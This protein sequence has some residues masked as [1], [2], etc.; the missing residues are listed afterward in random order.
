MLVIALLASPAWAQGCG[1]WIMRGGTEYHYDASYER[2]KAT[3]TGHAA[4]SAAANAAANNPAS[5]ANESVQMDRV[6]EKEAVEGSDGK[7][8]QTNAATNQT[9][10][11][12]NQ[13][14]QTV[15]QTAAAPKEDVPVEDPVVDLAGDWRVMIDTT[16]EGQNNQESID[17][18]LIQTGE[19]LQ[20]YGTIPRAGADISV[21]ATGHISDESL[22]LNVKE[23]GQNKEYR[24]DLVVLGEEM[25]A[26]EGMEGSYKIYEDAKLAG[27]GNA[28]A[29]KAGF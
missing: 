12:I 15:N 22:G 9:A 20:G 18:I 19:R 3:S 11:A 21:T 8:N 10:E 14:A 2:A 27:S 26:A 29:S 25:T 23:V 13:T 7:E 6:T 4:A 16:V 5:P 28:T 17:L 24:L 1:T